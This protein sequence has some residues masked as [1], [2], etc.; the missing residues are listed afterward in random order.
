MRYG[1]LGRTG[2]RVSQV[3]LGT[4]AFNGSLNARYSAAELARAS[5][6]HHSDFPAA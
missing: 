6:I 2:L 5:Q 3:G 4:W 1:H